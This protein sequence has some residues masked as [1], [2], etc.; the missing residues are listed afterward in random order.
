MPIYEYACASCGHELEIW[1][2]ITEKPARTCPNC[3]ARKLER[4]ISHTS[5][6]LKGTGWYVTDYAGKKPTTAPSADKPGSCPKKSADRGDD[7]AS[8]PPSKE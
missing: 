3:G 4:Q 1:Q 7:K 2:K 5:F 8:S 6:Q